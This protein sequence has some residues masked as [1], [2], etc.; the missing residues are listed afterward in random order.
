MLLKPQVLRN[1]YALQM[2]IKLGPGNSEWTD[3]YNEV[4][5]CTRAESHKK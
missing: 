1:L 3:D 2:S 5:F 4:Y